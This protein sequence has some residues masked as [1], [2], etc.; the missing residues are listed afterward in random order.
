LQF[1]LF[2]NSKRFLR[3][4]TV[5][6]HLGRTTLPQHHLSFAVKHNNV[7]PNAH[8]RKNWQQRV[9]TWLDQA[10][11][12]KSRR[13]ARKAKA[14][15]VAPRPTQA[16]RP[17]VRC[18][19]VRY[20]TRVRAGRGFTLAEVKAAGLTAKYAT[21]VGVAVDHRRRNKSDES[22]NE[23]AKRLRE[24]VS[25]LVVFPRKQA[26]PKKGDASKAD[27]AAAVQVTGEVLPIKRVQA[28]PEFVALTDDLKNKN[29]YLALRQARTN[30]KLV[31]I[32]ARKAKE[33]AEAVPAK[34]TE[35]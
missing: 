11:R 28:K 20:N 10:G 25:K 31:G 35:E 33:A 32:R 6:L 12:K 5:Q 26:H 19:T 14:A 21:S 7:L 4:T 16:L 18:Q 34:P 23:N 17:V 27:Q 15:R 1:L 22:L 13:I 8:F 9:K 24:Y 30:A 29:A 3:C 2:Y